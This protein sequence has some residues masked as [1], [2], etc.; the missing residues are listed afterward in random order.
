VA[1]DPNAD[2]IGHVIHGD[3][4]VTYTV[5]GSETWSKQYVKLEA[6]G[7]PPTCRPAG[8]VRRHKQLTE[9]P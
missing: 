7:H 8:I 1:D 2:L 4:G 5:T 3:D 9:A 6:E